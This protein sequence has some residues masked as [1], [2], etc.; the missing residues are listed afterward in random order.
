VPLFLTVYLKKKLATEELGIIL[1]DLSELLVSS[2][3]LSCL[4]HVSRVPGLPALATYCPRESTDYFSKL[5]HYEINLRL[6]PS[7]T[8]LGHHLAYP[9][10]CLHEPARQET[11]RSIMSKIYTYTYLE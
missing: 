5:V 4:Q 6:S 11:V 2:Q 10:I 7:Q 1:A 3:Q 9:S 8:H